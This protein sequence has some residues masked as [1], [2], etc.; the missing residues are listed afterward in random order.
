MFKR[1][2]FLALFMVGSNAIGI[3]GDAANVQIVQS[4]PVETNLEQPDLPHTKD[5]WIQM[6]KDAKRTVDIAQMYISNQ[7]GEALEPVLKEIE[8]AATRK[9]NPVHFRF[10]FSKNMIDSDPAA[11]EWVK[12]LPNSELF[13]LDLSKITG[14]IIHAKYIVVDQEQS[15]IGSQNLDWKALTQIHETGV[16]I[17]DANIARKLTQIF[18][19]D[20]EIVKT[21]KAPTAPKMT[22]INDQKFNLSGQNTI[23][24]V[25]SPPNMLP[26]SVGW[27]FAA[28]KNLI[29][30]ANKSLK[31]QVMNYST[32][33]FRGPGE[34]L[35]LDQTLRA[36]AARGV[37][38]Q[39]MV[40]DWNCAPGEITSIKNLSKVPNIDLRVV[41]IPEASSGFISYAR[42]IHSKYMI[43]D[44]QSYWLGTSNWSR[45]YFHDTRGVEL[46]FRDSNSVAIGNRIF[47]K[48]WDS[49]FTKVL[50]P[51]KGCILPRK[52]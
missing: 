14:G 51:A 16:L 36:A 2:L 6:I 26:N 48:L 10:M 9:V 39:M 5:V 25:G 8:K 15:F 18:D 37:K 1:I 52:F 44:D 29:E 3:P 28:L 42:V 33:L 41:T 49:K 19:I 24:L 50:D 32:F 27:S 47:Q 23:E 38:I 11:I 21:G 43:V 17:K 35:E 34:W 13:V 7:A 45:G 22:K 46:I 31:I 30:H 40:A 20:V 4:I 12:K